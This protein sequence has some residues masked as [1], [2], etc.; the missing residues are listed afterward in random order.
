M[1]EWLRVMQVRLEAEVIPDLVLNC[2]HE[3]PKSLQ[4]LYPHGTMVGRDAHDLHVGGQLAENSLLNALTRAKRCLL[5]RFLLQ[6]FLLD[7]QT[8]AKVQKLRG[9]HHR[10]NVEQIHYESQ[11]LHRYMSFEFSCFFH[12]AKRVE[13]RPR[14]RPISL[15]F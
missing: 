9:I 13:K 4:M 6:T 14:P 3:V 10:L 15:S 1:N 8:V 5:N 12:F 7:A 2:C 11:T